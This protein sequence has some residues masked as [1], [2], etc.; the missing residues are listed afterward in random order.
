M[1]NLSAKYDPSASQISEVTERSNLMN[2][3]MCL[4]YISGHIGIPGCFLPLSTQTHTYRDAVIA[5]MYKQGSSE[6]VLIELNKKLQTLSVVSTSDEVTLCEYVATAAYLCNEMDLVKEVLLRVPPTMVTTYVQ[7]LYQA[8][9][10]KQWSG[11]VFQTVISQGA[12]RSLE[13]WGL[14]EGLYL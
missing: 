13:Q 1:L 2:P 3:D 8:I 11:E 12:D 7:T 4:A 10:L 9:A 14:V 5:L 6:R